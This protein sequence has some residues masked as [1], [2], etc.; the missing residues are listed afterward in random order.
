M[1]RLDETLS[2]FMVNIAFEGAMVAKYM[3]A[4][5]DRDRPNYVG[6]GVVIAEDVFEVLE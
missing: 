5:K 4:G 2:A 1:G 3:V 6:A